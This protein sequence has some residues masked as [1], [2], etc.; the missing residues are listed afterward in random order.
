MEG[1]SEPAHDD[2]GP[3]DHALVESYRSGNPE[4]AGTLFERHRKAA[5]GY[6]RHLAGASHAEDVASEAFLKTLRAIVAGNGPTSNFRSY[7]LTT[8]HNTY[9]S[10]VRADAPY[11]LQPDFDAA[12]IDEPTEDEDASLRAIAE[13]FAGLP[14]RWQTVL[15]YTLIERHTLD[16]TAA[17]M[18][19][20]AQAAG[21]LRYR[22]RN[23]LYQAVLAQLPSRDAECAAVRRLLKR[24]P[25]QLTRRNRR[26]INDHLP[27]CDPCS[28]A[29][30][31]AP[32]G[33]APALAILAG[34]MLGGGYFLLGPPELAAA[35][36]A[37]PVA[38]GGAGGGPA[39]GPGGGS[40]G[41][42]PPGGGLARSLALPGA[43][44]L[45]LVLIIVA[46]ALGRPQPGEVADEAPPPAP[47]APVAPTE[48]AP[49]EAPPTEPAP[50]EPAPTSSAPTRPPTSRPP[51]PSTQPPA[52]T[53]PAPP[54]STAPATSAP[55]DSPPVQQDP[56]FRNV[57]VS[58]PTAGSYDITFEPSDV[59]ASTTIDFVV[60][61]LRDVRISWGPDIPTMSCSAPVEGKFRCQVRA[62]VP[63]GKVTVR[64]RTG[65]PLKG[66]MIMSDSEQGDADPSNNKITW[67]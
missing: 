26:L 16:E 15:W 50:T 46:V 64:L 24:D 45:V 20:T 23:G 6:A 38:A 54:E 61:D 18:G 21:S 3:R 43:V 27:D 17:A 67:G 63:D 65:S 29:A 55:A 34:T 37:V 30:K 44:V 56:S 11:V 33:V 7:L 25:D 51:A 40:G 58:N 28:R 1:Q 42:P 52:A 47:V 19:I 5:L 39:G 8:V 41:G 60:A 13:A 36:A 57:S 66:S 2:A 62:A 9:V 35:A 22:A 14:E 4:A 10:L 31:A 49:T 59:A 12:A 48:P 53:S 32:F